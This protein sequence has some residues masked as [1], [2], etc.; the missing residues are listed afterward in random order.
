M[1]IKNSIKNSLSGF[2]Q[3]IIIILIGFV[4]QKIFLS[5]LG[6]EY[7]GLNGL[8]NN[9]ITM[10][11][12]TELGIGTAI[13]YNLYKPLAENNIEEI[14]SLMKFYKKSYRII[15]LIVAVVGIA[16]I[17]FLPFIVGKTTITN[18]WIF[19]S[20]FLIDIVLSYLLTYKRSILQADQKNY[21]INYTHMISTIVLNIFQI[22]ILLLTKNYY[23]YLILKIIFRILENVIINSIVVKLYPYILDKK[24]KKIKKTT[25]KDIK[26]KIEGIIFHKIAT[27]FVSGTDNILISHFFGV[28]V[29]G[30]YSSY[31]LVINS[32]NTLFNQIIYSVTSSVGNLLVV[33]T[34][35]KKYDIYKKIKFLNSWLAIFSATAIFV[36]M[37]SFI[38]IWLGEDYLLSTGVLLVLV[39][40]YY[41]Q[42][43]KATFYVFKDA[44]GIYY[45]DRFVPLIESIA[46]IVFSIIFAK[47]FGLIGI[48]I[49]T[50]SSQLILH[51]YDF[52]YFAY[53]KIFLKNYKKYILEFLKY[54]IV[55]AIILVITYLSSQIIVFDN[56][57][58][59]FIKNTLLAATV[60]NLTLLVIFCKSEE[61]K[62]YLNIIRKK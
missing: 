42:S 57:Y 30:L 3:N 33:E 48:F 19:Y 12:I 35:E 32:V 5:T 2:I 22:T 45:E 55:F 40:N 24:I 54:L 16:I 6:E 28:S 18:I 50:I 26:L 38:T 52:Y 11:G 49:G 34:T 39:I 58:I 23:L 44:A 60:P 36:I 53:K 25:I 7:L 62:Y 59:N 4:A 20:L 13:I 27:F 31:F 21:Y 10:L 61:F 1:R 47:L 43:I 37:E 14:K 17:P 41:L 46:N 51:L 29:V 8:F 56:I 9:I 15:A